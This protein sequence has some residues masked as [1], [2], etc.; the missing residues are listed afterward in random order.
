M[1]CYRRGDTSYR[2]NNK[3]YRL[4]LSGQ[5]RGY[6]KHQGQKNC[7]N[8]TTYTSGH[9]GGFPRSPA[10]PGP[11]PAA[12]MRFGAAHNPSG[13]ILARQPGTL[14][15]GNRQLED[16]TVASTTLS[17]GTTFGFRRCS[18]SIA[19]LSNFEA[20]IASFKSRRAFTPSVADSYDVVPAART[21]ASSVVSCS[22]VIVFYQTTR[23]RAFNDVPLGHDLGSSTGTVLPAPIPSAAA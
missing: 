7:Q 3:K 1:V 14:R 18:C 19:S 23:T 17:G 11:A 8:D 6:H 22:Q 5:S 20:E 4:H 12:R 15:N 21:T 9:G 10:S 16:G 2:P 13:N